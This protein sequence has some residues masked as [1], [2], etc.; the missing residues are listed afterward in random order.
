MAPANA[1][2]IVKIRRPVTGSF[3]QIQNDLLSNAEISWKATGLLAYLLSLRAGYGISLEGLCKR[4]I[5]K[6]ASVRSGMKELEALGYLKIVRERGSSGQFLGTTWLVSD[7]PIV[8]WDPYLENPAMAQQALDEPYEAVQGTTNTNLVSIPKNLMT[9]TS[10]IELPQVEGT[11]AEGTESH[12][13]QEAWS[14][15]CERLSIDPEQTRQQSR[16]L[17]SDTALNVLIET[18]SCKVQ[19][20]IKKTVDQFL[21]GLLQRAAMGKFNLSA[22]RKSKDD[23]PAI[24]ARQRAVEEAYRSTPQIAASPEA[25][26]ASKQAVLAAREQLKHLNEMTK[27]RFV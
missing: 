10:P 24:L 17:D 18:Y 21:A 14:W 1:S 16:G 2:K 9:T 8:D 5:D 19:G 20:S 25:T 7:C 6:E 11:E 15:L 3:A 4:K 22:G 26:M 27:Q 13:H 23:L 12:F